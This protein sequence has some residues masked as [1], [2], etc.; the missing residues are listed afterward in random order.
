MSLKKKLKTAGKD[1]AHS[2]KTPENIRRSLGFERSHCAV[3]AVGSLVF[4]SVRGPVWNV[5]IAVVSFCKSARVRI[6]ENQVS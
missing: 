4:E 3:S 2:S 6:P 1:P 5:V